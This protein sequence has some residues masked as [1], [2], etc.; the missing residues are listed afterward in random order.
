MRA[1]LEYRFSAQK[2]GDVTIE[3]EQLVRLVEQLLCLA[4]L[5]TQEQF[6]CAAFDA[7]AVAALL[8]THRSDRSTLDRRLALG[9]GCGSAFPARNTATHARSTCSLPRYP[10]RYPVW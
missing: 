9:A 6:Q 1:R 3:I 7:H 2:L 8:G 10:A 5:N 4:R